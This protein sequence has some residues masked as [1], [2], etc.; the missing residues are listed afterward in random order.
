MTQDVRSL[1]ADIAAIER[2]I[3]DYQVVVT[4]LQTA[5][6]IMARQVSAPVQPAPLKQL[7]APARKAMPTARKTTKP[8][9]IIHEIEGVDITVTPLQS[10]ILDA[11]GAA[12]DSVSDAEMARIVGST[13]GSVA[14]TV[15]D[16]RQRLKNA[17]CLAEIN[18]HN[19]GWRLEVERAETP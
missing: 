3:A 11:L 14:Q 6:D 4:A 12:E 8:E 13:I 1:S 10:A 9:P 5:R 15:R 19:G 18:R 2:M 16:L 17:K 7:P